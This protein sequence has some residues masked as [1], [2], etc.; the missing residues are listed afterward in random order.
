MTIGILKMTVLRLYKRF[1]LKLLQL[2]Q[3][4]GNIGWAEGNKDNRSTE[5][6]D[7]RGT[8]AVDQYIKRKEEP[9]LQRA[10]YRQAVSHE[11]TQKT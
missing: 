11:T 7:R 1:I 8:K 10:L 4:K 3:I 2:E 5:I 6:T 9:F